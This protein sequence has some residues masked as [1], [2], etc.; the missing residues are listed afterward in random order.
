MGEIL[1]VAAH[2]GGV[3]KTTCAVN[4]SALWAQK[5][6]VLLANV[7]PQ[8]NA[9]RGLGVNKDKVSLTLTDVLEDDVPVRNAIIKAE[10]GISFLPSNESL[11][12][13][14][15]ANK[16]RKVLAPLRKEYDAIVIDCPPAIGSLTVQSLIAADQ[17]LIPFRPGPYEWDGLQQIIGTIG[18]IKRSGANPNLRVLGIF[19]TEADIRT[20]LFK[21]LDKTMQKS[22]YGKLLFKTVIRSAVKVSEAPFYGQPIH[23]YNKKAAGDYIKL[24]KE[25]LERWGDR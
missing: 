4:L 8:G 20:K 2:K 7:D 11:A 12:Q 10:C 21:S 22:S 14:V 24:S 25:V 23:L 19:Y 15:N 13:V 6:K 17:V 18:T 5:K 16:L 1:C 3:G 9:G